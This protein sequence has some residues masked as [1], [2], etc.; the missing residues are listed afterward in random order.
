MRHRLVVVAA[1]AL[2]LGPASATGAPLSRERV[3]APLKPW[4]DWVLHGQEDALCPTVQGDDDE[5]RCAWPSRLELV[6]DD[7]GGAFS[8]GWWVEHEQWVALPGDD[9]RW[10][11]DVRAGGRS[12]IVVAR[13]GRPSV[14][15]ESGAHV[16]TGRFTWR[17][18]P[19]SLP[20]PA[21]TGLLALDVRAAAVP[22]PQRDGE[23]RVWLQRQAE[24]E[25]SESR[26]DLTVHRRLVDDV[27]LY[28]DTRI[29]L[30]VSGESREEL[31]GRALLPGFTPTELDSPLP[32]RLEPD[33]RLRVQVRPG[34]WTLTLTARH[35]GPVPALQLVDAGEPWAASEV[36]VFEARLSVSA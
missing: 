21:S 4:V 19:E 6:L 30:E 31:L 26:L 27:P 23:G 22:F 28:V 35:D 7:A 32:A 36:W 16:V 3:P 29:E 13:D 2:G 14:R 25:R 1:L 17:G 20:I 11:F 18:L 9:Q 15:L 5:R 8:Q 33:G 10:P 12:G 34:R 24:E